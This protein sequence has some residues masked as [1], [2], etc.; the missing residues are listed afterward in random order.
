M[1]SLI[2]NNRCNIC[3]EVSV[4]FFKKTSLAPGKRFLCRHCHAAYK[5]SEWG[6]LIMIF[7]PF[8]MVLCTAFGFYV[9]QPASLIAIPLVFGA[10]ILSGGL[11]GL[12]IYYFVPLIHVE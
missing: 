12:V 7:I 3:G 6:W 10:G 9:L 11:L 1:A 4:G 5:V 2:F 8:L